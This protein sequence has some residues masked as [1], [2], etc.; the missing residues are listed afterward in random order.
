[1]VGNKKNKSPCSDICDFSGPHGWCVGCGRTRKE[2]D[3]WKKL[4][5]YD[6]KMIKKQLK[7]R[8]ALIAVE[9]D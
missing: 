6:I 5:S 1:M 2:C 8:L 9:I 3:K 4:C 7:R